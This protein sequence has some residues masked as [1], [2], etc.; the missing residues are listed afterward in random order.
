MSSWPPISRGRTEEAKTRE[1]E[2][3]WRVAAYNAIVIHNTQPF[4][5]MPE[6]SRSV[7]KASAEQAMQR[8]GAEAYRPTRLVL[9]RAD[10][11]KHSATS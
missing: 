6:H 9:S 2:R 1:T 11:Y 8:K 10:V 5:A 3:V 4:T 7:F